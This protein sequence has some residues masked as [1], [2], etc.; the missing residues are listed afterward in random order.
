MWGLVPHPV[1]DARFNK[2]YSSSSGDEKLFMNYDF[3]FHEMKTFAILQ[4]SRPAE[5]RGLAVF[6]SSISRLS[7]PAEMCCSWHEKPILVF[8]DNYSCKNPIFSFGK[9]ELM[10]DIPMENDEVKVNSCPF[11]QGEEKSLGSWSEE[12]I[13][14]L[15]QKV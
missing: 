13:E 1:A 3:I 10:L 8:C 11:A 15:S 9:M 12:G 7:Y 2:R 4:W 14:K 5:E 6:L